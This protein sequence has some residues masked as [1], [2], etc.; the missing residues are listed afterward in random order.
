[1]QAP[2]TQTHIEDIILNYIQKKS[3]ETK[4]EL[5]NEIDRLTKK[6]ENLE[7]AWNKME[8]FEKKHLEELES[9]YEIP[10]KNTRCFP[11]NYLEGAFYAMSREAQNI[12]LLLE[13]LS[14][15]QFY[16]HGISMTYAELERDLGIS[17]RTSKK[18]FDILIQK[19]K[20]V[21]KRA[22]GGNLYKIVDKT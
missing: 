8:E 7:I 3:D 11:N 20:V 5:E 15:D 17:S 4:N 19:G 22:I 9:I 6:S 1:M 13:R 21:S 14:T 12:D 16:S 2:I 10:S 18:Y